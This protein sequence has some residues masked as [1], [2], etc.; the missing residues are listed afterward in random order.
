MTRA[1]LLVAK[2]LGWHGKQGG[3]CRQGAE[4][5]AARGLVSDLEDIA[6][7]AMPAC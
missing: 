3:T 2:G 7:M 5:S 6:D 4:G 1:S